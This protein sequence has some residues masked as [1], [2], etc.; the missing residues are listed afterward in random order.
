M[1]DTARFMLGL[2]EEPAVPP[3][4]SDFKVLQNFCGAGR[5]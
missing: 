3:L 1:S 2:E 4:T 5:Y